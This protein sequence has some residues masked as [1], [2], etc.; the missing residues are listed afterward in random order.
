MGTF[1]DIIVFGVATG[2][3]VNSLEQGLDPVGYAGS[4]VSLAANGGQTALSVSETLGVTTSS[5]TALTS[6]TRALGAAGAVGAGLTAIQMKIDFDAGKDLKVG[7][8]IIVDQPY[9]PLSPSASRNSR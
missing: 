2:D 1:T 7:D 4:V 8:T 3:T 6:I 9:S 5:V